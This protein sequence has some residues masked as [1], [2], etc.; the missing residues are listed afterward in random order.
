MALKL[1]EKP[2][3]V[4]A[5]GASCNL[6]R[7]TN[8]FCYRFQCQLLLE[9]APDACACL[10]G[11]EKAPV[12]GMQ[13]RYSILVKRG[14]GFGIHS[15][16]K[17]VSLVRHARFLSFFKFCDHLCDAHDARK[18]REIPSFATPSKP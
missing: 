11:S 4:F 2:D 10:V 18:I 1:G 5:C 8:F 16:T 6:I 3:G 12:T 9:S 13:D 15:K 7:L 17:T 14:S